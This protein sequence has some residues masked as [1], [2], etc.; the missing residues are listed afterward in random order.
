MGAG[1]SAANFGALACGRPVRCTGVLRSSRR[2]THATQNCNFHI[3]LVPARRGL[4]GHADSTN[5]TPLAVLNFKRRL[6]NIHRAKM[7]AI[8]LFAPRK[9]S[10]AVGG[11]HVLESFGPLP[12]MLVQ[13]GFLI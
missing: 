5:S 10:A 6:T 3:N 11:S 13:K 9:A 12:L 8:H 7:Q 4:P 1:R 2:T